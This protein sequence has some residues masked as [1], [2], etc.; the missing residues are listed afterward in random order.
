MQT[1]TVRSSRPTRLPGAGLSLHGLGR[2]LAERS[3]TPLHITLFLLFVI[4][5]SRIHQSFSFISKLR[6]GVLLIAVAFLFL[7]LQP[8]SARLHNLVDTWPAKVVIGLGLLACVSAP[9]GISLGASVLFLQNNYSRTLV[10]AFLVMIAIRNAADLRVFIWA[11]V[12]SLAGVLYIAF[13]SPMKRAGG[14]DMARLQLSQGYDPNDVGVILVGGIPIVLL[15]MHSTGRL[16]KI[17]CLGILV[18]IAS[19]IARTG[20]RGAFVG[21]VALGLALLFLLNTISVGK[22]IAAVVVVALGVF[23]AAPEGYWDRMSGLTNPTEDYNWTAPSGRRELAKRSV[24]Y[25]FASPFGVGIGMFGRA[26]GTVSDLAQERLASGR[27][28]KWSTA[29]NSFLQVGAEMGLL[30]I[31]LWSS[32]IVGG[33]ATVRRM[34]ARLPRTWAR[35]RDVDERFLYY[36]SLYMPAAIIGFA[37]TATFV[38]F[39]YMSPIYIIS[40]YLVGSIVVM[41]STAARLASPEA[42]P[43]AALPVVARRERGGLAGRLSARPASGMVASDG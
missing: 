23:I 26:E 2:T 20:S 15:A 8:R 14:W 34:H 21:L 36:F 3:W 7:L 35:S 17:I 37:V 33:M 1:H 41:R 11:H 32:L 38:S 25:M 18:G 4:N 13:T 43:V 6:P 28:I 16:G 29:H 30:G 9:F 39:A 27:G 5:L 12:T 24:Q 40:A 42:Q 19:T 22:R 31:V 10:F